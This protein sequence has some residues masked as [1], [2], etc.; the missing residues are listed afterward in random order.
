MG[1][2][3]YFGA[4][5]VKGKNRVF[6]PVAGPDFVD[7]FELRLREPKRGSRSRSVNVVIIG[8]QSLVQWDGEWRR[9]TLATASTDC[10]MTLKSFDGYRCRAPFA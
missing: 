1:I 6:V 4:I 10:C 2:Q 5:V 3:R 9:H 8:F 7:A